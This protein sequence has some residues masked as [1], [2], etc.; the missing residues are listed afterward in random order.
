[1]AKSTKIFGLTLHSQTKVQKSRAWRKF[2]CAEGHIQAI[3]TMLSQCGNTPLIRLNKITKDTTSK[4][5]HLNPG[6]YQDRIASIIEE[7][8]RKGIPNSDTIIENY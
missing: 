5:R 4:S 1:V 7:A 2:F 3:L 6:H 8:E